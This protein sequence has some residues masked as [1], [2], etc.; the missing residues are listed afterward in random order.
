VV[1]AGLGGDDPGRLEPLLLGDLVHFA[2]AFRR[3]P[4]VDESRF[5][6]KLVEHL[7]RR[8]PHGGG[9]FVP[10]AGVP[11]EGEDLLASAGK[12][13]PNLHGGRVALHTIALAERHLFG[14]STLLRKRVNDIVA[15]NAATSGH[16]ATESRRNDH[17]P[18][19][20]QP[21]DHAVLYSNVGGTVVSPR[22]VDRN[23]GAEDAGGISSR[24][25]H[26]EDLGEA[27]FSLLLVSPTSVP[28]EVVAAA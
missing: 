16:N 26:N 21:I 19:Q 6:I 28:S 4:D 15:P 10:R 25:S 14:K 20:S 18:P 7:A 8:D 2:D 9:I 5:G 13:R 17:H 3:R 11:E 1:V 23:F 22:T 12:E 24:L 27:P